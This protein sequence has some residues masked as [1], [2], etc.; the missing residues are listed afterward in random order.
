M[1]KVPRPPTEEERKLY[2]KPEINNAV[3]DIVV[4]NHPATTTP[5][6]TGN[7]ANMVKAF[8]TAGADPVARRNN[9]AGRVGAYKEKGL[10]ITVKK[11]KAAEETVQEATTTNENAPMDVDMEA[12][13]YTKPTPKQPEY[14]DY[15]EETG[16]IDHIEPLF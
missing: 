8:E 14:E 5:Q 6:G 13:R 15:A 1:S 12:S 9:A 2:C 4:V 10:V 16:D 11:N 7:V 3:T